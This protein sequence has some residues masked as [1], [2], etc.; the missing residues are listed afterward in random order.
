MSDKIVVDNPKCEAASGCG[1]WKRPTMK[2]PKYK[3]KWVRPTIDNPDYKVRYIV[4]YL[5]KLSQSWLG[6]C[7]SC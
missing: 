6:L 4:L 7:V 3:G 5:Q 2:N 1:E